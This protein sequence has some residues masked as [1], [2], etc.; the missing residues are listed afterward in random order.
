MPS[1]LTSAEQKE[2]EEQVVREIQESGDLDA[3]N[4][5]ID[6]LAILGLALIVAALVAPMAVPHLQ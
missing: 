1:W 5:H 3:P 4:I 6:V 2:L